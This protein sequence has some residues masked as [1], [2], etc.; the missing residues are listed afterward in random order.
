V[1]G[2]IQTTLA[3]R[4]G[5]P[6]VAVWS[7]FVIAAMGESVSRS[8]AA[9]STMIGALAAKLFSRKGVA[10][11]KIGLKKTTEAAFFAVMFH[12]T[13]LDTLSL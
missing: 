10:M 13:G 6:A 3:T 2:Y 1:G 8:A 7:V 4:D 11:I 5:F 9:G 12:T